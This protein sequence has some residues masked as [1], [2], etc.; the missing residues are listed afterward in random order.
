MRERNISGAF[1]D[2]EPAPIY[3]YNRKNH[4]ASK[5]ED[6]GLS[7]S[8]KDERRLLCSYPTLLGDLPHVDPSK[9]VPIWSI[10]NKINNA[11]FPKTSMRN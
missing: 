10:D 1:V 5:K 4:A 2:D 9:R 8:Y 6:F 3:F 11:N 7:L